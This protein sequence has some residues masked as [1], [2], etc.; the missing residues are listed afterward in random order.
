MKTIKRQ[1]YIDR[2]KPFIDSNLIK[3]FTGSRRAGKSVLM[4]LV[5]NELIDRGVDPTQILAINF[6]SRIDG[7]PLTGE[8]VWNKVKEKIDKL[9]KKVYLFFDE[10]QE[11]NEWEKIVNSIQID[12][13][14]DIYLTGSN[15]KLLSS[16]LSTYL[17]GRYIEIKVY[18]FSFKE[19]V[20]LKE[21]SNIV[22]DKKKLFREYIVKGGYPVLYN[23][24]MSPEDEMLYL[25]D[26]FNSIIL[27]DVAQRNNIRDVALFKQIV[28]FIMANVGNL[29]SA[30]SIIKYLKNEN[31]KLSTETLYNYIDFCKSV[32]LVNMIQRRNIIGKEILSS[33]NKIYMID[34]GLRQAIYG[35]NQR[36]VN[37]ILEN[38]VCVELQRRGYNVMIGCIGT[39]EVDFCAT[40]NEEVIYFQV[41]YLL[42]SEETIERE[43]G[44][45]T[46][47][48]DNYPKYVLSLDELD[49]SRDGIIHKNIVEWLLE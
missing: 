49:F 8:F 46:A 45:L 4:Q 14:V 9:D 39:K 20:Q 35:N 31:R 44:S 5:Q 38:I 41:T 48:Q 42:A 32:Y 30:T 34:H 22:I 36:D 15:A 10:V 29:F 37:Q 47:I 43:F 3:V 21:E 18:P 2:V 28:I 25:N 24:Q 40:K 11:L 19:V 13:D 27:K 16:E 26:L 12:F 17:S 1:I 7:K 23:Y 6:E 33:Q